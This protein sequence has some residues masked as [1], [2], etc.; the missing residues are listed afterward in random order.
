MDQVMDAGDSS[1]PGGTEVVR[2][3]LIKLTLTGAGESYSKPDSQSLRKSHLKKRPVPNG[4]RFLWYCRSTPVLMVP[5]ERD[6]HHC[7]H[8]RYI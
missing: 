3:D 8:A 2:V 6:P 5:G 1:D 4:N 7:Q